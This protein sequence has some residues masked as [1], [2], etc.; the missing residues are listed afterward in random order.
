MILVVSL[1]PAWQRTLHFPRLALGEVNR[2]SR[3]D[4]YASGKGVNVAR[5]AGQ[6]GADV[7][8]L[9]ALGG[10]RGARLARSLKA[11]RIAAR[12]VRCAAQT[13]ICQT[14]LDASNAT[15]LVE[16]SAPLT[17]RDVAAV[18]RAFDSELRRAKILVLIGSAPR[19]VEKDFYATL[20]ASA[21]RRNIPALV[22]AQ[23]DLLLR[24]VRAK[25]FLVRVNRA[26]LAAATGPPRKL[27]LSLTFAAAQRLVR[28]GASWVVVSDGANEVAIAS[29]DGCWTITPPRIRA[30]NPV[31]SGDAMLAGIAAG[32][33][34]GETALEAVRYAVACGVANALTP[35]AG[36]VSR[37][38]VARLVSN[39]KCHQRRA[40]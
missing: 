29:R 5:V 10:E 22:D 19:G 1:S 16:E 17:S 24:A 14:L 28:L 23:G 40:V 33:Q 12:I 4:E 3:V 35:I 38:T 18:F 13:R 7:K 32:L 6:L 27:S 20:I 21:A 36:S 15:E 8:L 11:Q 30:V 39:I 34:R 25:P 9:T 26:E 2:A 31:G 37:A